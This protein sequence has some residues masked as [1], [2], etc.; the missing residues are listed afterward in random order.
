MAE[1][2]LPAAGGAKSTLM[3]FAYT[4]AEQTYVTQSSGY[5]RL[6]AAGARGGNGGFGQG[7]KTYTG[8]RGAAGGYF[9]GIAFIPAGTTINVICGGRGADGATSYGSAGAG[10]AGGWLGAPNGGVGTGNNAQRSG[11]GGGGGGWSGFIINGTAVAHAGGGSGGSGGT[12]CYNGSV[13]S[14][15]GGAG[16]GS[17]GGATRGGI[18]VSCGETWSG[19]HG[20]DGNAGSAAANNDVI[21]W[22]KTKGYSSAN[23]E[24]GWAS[25]EYIGKRIG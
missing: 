12:E 22:A 20:Y 11:G 25:I 15:A 5:F 9:D 7:G 13:T 4:G 10:G 3:Y 1:T 19:G 8:G 23:Y 2:L 24:F 17:T 21:A 6:I 16:G 18:Y 14:G